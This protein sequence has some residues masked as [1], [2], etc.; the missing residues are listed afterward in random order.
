ML[1]FQ[2]RI[3]GHLDQRLQRSLFDGDHGGFWVL[4]GVAQGR[5]AI[6]TR[7]SAYKVFTAH[8]GS[9]TLTAEVGA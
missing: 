4:E 9:A 7:D 8:S 2:T 5:D 1:L 3:K 6:A